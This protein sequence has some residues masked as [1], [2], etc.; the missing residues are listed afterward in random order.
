MYI[1]SDTFIFIRNWNYKNRLVESE[2]IFESFQFT[3]DMKHL[4]EDF[5]TE[6]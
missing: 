4:K 1:P 5:L 6:E 3:R 2:I